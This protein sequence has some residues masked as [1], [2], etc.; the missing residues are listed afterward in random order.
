[1]R[2]I[3]SLS[4]RQKPRW[5]PLV[6]DYFTGRKNVF[7]SVGQSLAGQFQKR[8][9]SQNAEEEA[10]IRAEQKEKEEFDGCIA[11]LF[12][13]KKLR[14]SHK[15]NLLAVYPD[16]QLERFWASYWEKFTLAL[17]TSE[18]DA[19]LELLAFWFDEFFETLLRMHEIP[20]GFFLG[21]SE[22]LDAA[23]K[24]R[25]FRDRARQISAKGMKSNQAYP[26]YPVVQDYFVEQER[27]FP[28]FRRG[29]S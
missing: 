28:F 2:Q 4:E 10:R 27:R 13:G 22:A 19:V 8:L 7:V 6:Q 26:W 29:S 5:Y 9:G 21:L 14:Q 3:N 18:A 25:G 20:Q 17:L 24:E 1:M 11:S 16:E 12:E 15:Q 23:R